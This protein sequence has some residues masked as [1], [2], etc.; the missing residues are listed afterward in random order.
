[1]SVVEQRYQAV[2]AVIGEGATV[3]EVAARLGDPPAMVEVALAKLRVAHMLQ[4]CRLRQ[5]C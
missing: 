5:H 1:M 2:Q 3:A 4:Q